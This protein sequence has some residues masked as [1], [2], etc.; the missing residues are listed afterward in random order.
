MYRHRAPPSSSAFYTPK[1]Q[2]QTFPLV[3]AR[4]SVDV[5]PCSYGSRHGAAAR[6]LRLRIVAVLGSTLFRYHSSHIPASGDDRGDGPNTHQADQP[7]AFLREPSSLACA[8]PLRL[9][10]SRSGTAGACCGLLWALAG[11][12]P[13]STLSRGA[14]RRLTDC[15]SHPR[16]V[17]LLPL[18]AAGWRCLSATHSEHHEY[19]QYQLTGGESG[20]VIS[21][22]IWEWGHHMF[23]INAA[24]RK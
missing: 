4:R 3:R 17:L 5:E 8:V 16:R 18:A 15:D 13:L 22:P 24:E 14:W 10:R 23:D 21:N 11:A 7:I 1:R 9:S 6:T 20:S 2:S 12:P 19:H